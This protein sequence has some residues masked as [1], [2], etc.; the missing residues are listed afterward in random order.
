LLAGI[1]GIIIAVLGIL[2][3]KPLF[4]F[5][6]ATPEILEL[7]LV[8]SN[9]I[10]IGFI[11]MFIG[12]I[13]QGIL[14][15]EGNSKTPMI[16]MAVSVVVNIVLDPIMIFGLFGFPALG[17]FGG[18][19]ATVIAR[20]I[21]AALNIIYILKGKGII[22][23]KPRDF[24]FNP[25]IMKAIIFLG[26]PA[27]AG[28]LTMSIGL[29][30]VMSFVGV[31]G[32]FAIASY[33]IGTRLDSLAILPVL[34]L[35]SATIAMVGQNTGAGKHER[36][37]KTIFYSAILSVLLM[38]LVA[39]VFLLVPSP[40]FKLFSSDEKVISIGIVYLSIVAFSY[41]FRGILMSILSGIQ[42][43]G[44]TVLAMVLTGAYWAL[45]VVLCF[46]LKDIYGLKGIWFGILGSSMIGALITIAVYRSGIWLPKEL[47]EKAL[48][49]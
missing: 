19:L 21:G 40:F 16:N 3:G 20:S 5:M 43:T 30:I 37:K 34:G 42:G 14:Q 41:P 15:A 48:M 26:S 39:V 25:K 10:F 6:G 12:F 17:V 11:F 13:S 23:I 45:I 4:V 31:F 2:F 29:T 49:N 8:Y 47:K 38:G 32:T 33:G 27:S 35:T 9:T 22:K 28:Q 36:A 46:F 7:T 24:S 44:N 1:T 18:A